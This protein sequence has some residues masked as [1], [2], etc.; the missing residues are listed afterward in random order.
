M[1]NN[2]LTC[3][4]GRHEPRQNLLPALGM[5]QMQ[6]HIGFLGAQNMLGSTSPMLQMSAGLQIPNKLQIAGAAQLLSPQHAQQLQPQALM[7]AQHTMPLGTHLSTPQGAA[8]QQMLAAHQTQMD[9][10]SSLYL[11]MYGGMCGASHCGPSVPSYAA[12]DMCDAVQAH[13]AA[14]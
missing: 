10:R 14:A 2:P 5:L 3:S 7:H 1:V 8:Q 6:N 11:D 4:W 12:V 9:S 13:S